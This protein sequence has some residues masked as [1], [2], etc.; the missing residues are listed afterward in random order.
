[1][2]R[3]LKSKTLGWRYLHCFSAAEISRISSRSES[4]SCPR[5]VL[6]IICLAQCSSSFRIFFLSDTLGMTDITKF[7]IRTSASAK[8]RNNGGSNLR[9]PEAMSQ[10]ELRTRLRHSEL[11]HSATLLSSNTYVIIPY[12]HESYSN[13]LISLYYIIFIHIYDDLST[14]VKPYVT[15]TPR[16]CRPSSPSALLELAT[17]V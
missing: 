10:A 17:G 16:P 5:G 7:E 11:C 15:A 6:T 12:A 9:R 1:M 8:K 3:F 14:S 13:I 4:S 2:L